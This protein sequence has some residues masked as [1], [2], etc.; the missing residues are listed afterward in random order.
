VKEG[1]A[2][3]NEAGAFEIEVVIRMPDLRTE[4]FVEE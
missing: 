2:L 3:L 1:S 4:E